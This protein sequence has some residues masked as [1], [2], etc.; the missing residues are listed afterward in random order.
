MLNLS[1]HLHNSATW[2]DGGAAQRGE[3]RADSGGL[4]WRTQAVPRRSLGSPGQKSGSPAPWSSSSRHDLARRRS[5]T[6]R[7]RRRSVGLSHTGRSGQ[8]V[9]R[10]RPRRPATP[11]R[12]AATRR[13]LTRRIQQPAPIAH[14]H[15]A[16]IAHHSPRLIAHL[17]AAHSAQA[18][19]GSGSNS[20]T[21][22]AGHHVQGQRGQRGWAAETRETSQ[23]RTWRGPHPRLVQPPPYRSGR[24]RRVW[25][26]GGT[27]ASA[28][29][30]STASS[31]SPTRSRCCRSTT[32]SPTPR[33]R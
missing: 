27:G 1:I 21:P 3:L 9:Q 6:T 26:R 31:R 4:G 8:R 23:R 30:R 7:S 20:A 13:P 17:T 11:H 29:C 24:G 22:T 16:P 14:Q 19:D 2:H 18:V 33:S 15:S 10:D 5:V 12:T 28:A 25:R 32:P